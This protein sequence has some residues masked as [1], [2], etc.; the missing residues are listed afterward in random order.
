MDWV[1]QVASRDMIRFNFSVLLFGMLANRTKLCR[2][3]LRC[4]GHATING[5]NGTPCLRRRF[6]IQAVELRVVVQLEQVRV[7][8]RPH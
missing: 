4:H 3:P 1:E 7:A 5:S 2:D 6:R 8:P